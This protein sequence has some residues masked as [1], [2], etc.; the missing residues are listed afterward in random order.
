M[1]IFSNATRI[2][3]PSGRATGSNLNATGE[4]GEPGNGIKSVWWQWRSPSNGT[5]TIDTVGSSFDTTLG[6]YTGT[7]VDRLTELAE[8]DAALGQQRRVTLRVTAGTVYWLRVSG[9]VFLFVGG[10]TGDIVLNWN[11]EATGGSAQHQYIFPQFPFGGG[12]RSTLT[13]LTDSN[14]ATTCTFSAQGRFLTMRDARGNLRTGTE[15]PLHGVFNLLKTTENQGT[16]VSSGMAVLD[17]NKEVISTNTLF[18]LEVGGSLVSEALVEPFEEVAAAPD[19]DVWF[20]ADY[21]DGARFGVAVAN[22][23]NQSLDVQVL[24]T[25]IDLEVFVNTTVNI[26]A[27]A[28]NAFFVDELGTIPASHVGQVLISPSNNPGPSVYAVGLR[29]TGLVFTTIPATV[30]P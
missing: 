27:N 15:L 17:C 24:V 28:A 4:S 9:L 12:W 10:G 7:Q 30:F 25:G 13:V 5:A 11:L 1:T 16:E 21:R 20:P 8:N 23:T 26:P 19:Y 6:I 29:F 2:S 22:P 14:A 18:S 3:G